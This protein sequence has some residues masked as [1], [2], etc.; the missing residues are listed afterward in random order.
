MI[1]NQIGG[2]YLNFAKYSFQSRQTYCRSILP[3][4]SNFVFSPF[5][6]LMFPAA[7]CVP[8]LTNVTPVFLLLSSFSVDFDFAAISLR[9]LL[10][11]FMVLPSLLLHSRPGQGQGQAL[12]QTLSEINNLKK[13]WLIYFFWK[14]NKRKRISFPASVKLMASITSQSSVISHCY[15]LLTIPTIQ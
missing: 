7:P 3:F 13:T 9:P 8:A 4:V 11:W 5:C 12:A 2:I 6:I 1:I 10:A 14:L 15:S